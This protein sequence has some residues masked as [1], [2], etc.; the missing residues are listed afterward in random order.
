MTPEDIRYARHLLPAQIHFP[1]YA[2]R[3]SPWLLAQQ[4]DRRACVR[5]L[6]GAPL[7]RFLDRP[8]VKPLVAG[9][10][11]T[12]RQRDIIAVAHAAEAYAFRD[13]SRAARHQIDTIWAGVWHDFELTFTHWGIDEPHD[14]AQMSR[15]GGN[16][17]LQLGF[18]SD[19]A[20][21]MGRYL[22]GDVRKE[23]LDYGH[24]V[25][26]EGRPTLAWSR[27]DLDLSTGQALIEEV[28]TDWLRLV[29]D[30]IRVL[31]NRRPQSRALQVTRAYDAA[32]RARY[33]RIWSQA[34]MLA[35]L[36]V[37]RD[38]LGIRDVFMHSPETGWALQET[39]PFCG[40]PVSLYRDLPRKFGFARSEDAPAFLTPAR[41]HDLATLKRHGHSF[42]RLQI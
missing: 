39:D 12:L 30:E 25:R 18:P 6:R 17:V 2:D 8:L 35:A 24:P 26:Q 3:E 19:H 4:M 34:L 32:L 23:F 29:R 20:E 16:L 42:W 11:G 15:D 5:D 22:T 33:D 1:Y 41:R 28:Q 36:I 10:G 9:S 40:P 7:A 27:L 21:L 14:W 37:L 31:E 38:Y 13:L